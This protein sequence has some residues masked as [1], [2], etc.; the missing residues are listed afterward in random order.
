[1]AICL[2]LTTAVYSQGIKVPEDMPTTKEEFVASEKP[3]LG[4]IDYLDSTAI[5][6]EPEKR[7]AAVT[8]L[9]SW[10]TNSPTVTLTVDARTTSFLKK[11]PELVG[12][13]MGGYTKYS[14]EHEY[15]KDQVACNVAGLQS[16]IKVYKMGNGAKKD[17]DLDKLAALD[18]KGELEKWV[19]EQ[20]S[21][22]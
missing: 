12:N 17:K 1:M 11:N 14:L 19:R 9:V 15:S 21:K 3:L 13:F 5:N 18:A 8:Y 16:V 20:L 22:K 7:R 2:L 4:I 6:K 10:L